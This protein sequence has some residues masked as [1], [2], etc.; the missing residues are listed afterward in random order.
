MPMAAG[1]QGDPGSLSARSNLSE[2][3]WPG[4]GGTS[5]LSPEILEE[6]GQALLE[7]RVETRPSPRVPAPLRPAYRL[8]LA[9][10]V[11]AAAARRLLASLP[12]EIQTGRRATDLAMLQELAAREFRVSGPITPG[13][14]QRAVA[15][16]GPTGVGKTT[17]IAKLAGQLRHAG[18]LNVAVITLDTYRIGAVAQM[19]IY[20]DLLGI[21]LHVVRTPVEMRAA[22]EAARG[23]DIV[24]VDT[25]GRSPREPEGIALTRRLLREVPDVEVH[26]VTSATTKGVDLEEILRRFRPLDYRRV[27]V[28]KLDEV[29]TYGP[30]LGLALQHQLVISYL[31]TG[32]EVPDDLEAATPRRLASLLVTGGAG[33]RRASMR[34][35]AGG[36]TGS[37]P[38][39]TKN[40]HRTTDDAKLTTHT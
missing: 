1:E 20:A 11:P 38:R 9:Q 35:L 37:R 14:R 13:R 39:T 6:I 18:G 22:L 33:P 10:D 21:P 2:V 4:E 23:A 12:P 5:P 15:L 40:G 3:A 34:P 17:T 26:L 29:R 16:V 19:R 25:T 28:T 31:S 32:Q 8:L 30:L 7:L 27:L 24:L 36:P